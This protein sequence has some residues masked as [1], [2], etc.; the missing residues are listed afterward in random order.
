[1]N[2]VRKYDSKLQIEFLRA[3]R[4]DKFKTPGTQINLGVKQDIFVLT[5]DQRHELQAINREFLLSSPTVGP[6][7]TSNLPM[8]EAG[9]PALRPPCRPQLRLGD[10]GK[11]GRVKPIAEMPRTLAA[12]RGLYMMPT[13]HCA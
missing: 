13:T 4:P 2:H 9:T 6:L 8:L 12:R 7:E 5:E 10:Q 1:M 3:Y 11:E